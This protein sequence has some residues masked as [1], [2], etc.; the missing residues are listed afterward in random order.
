MSRRQVGRITVLG[1]IVTAVLATFGP[2]GVAGAGG[3]DPDP[4]DGDPVAGQAAPPSGT[5]AE[6]AVTV[7]DETEYRN[8][9]TAL[10]LDAAGP[11][12]ITLTA[13]ITLSVGTDPLY[14]GSQALTLDGAGFTID[15]AGT[16]QILNFD[17]NA[18][19]TVR[20]ITMRNGVTGG[21]GGAVEAEGDLVVEGSVFEDNEADSEGGAIDTPDDLVVED[22]V[23]E[24]NEAGSDGGAADSGGDATLLRSR[25]TRNVAGDDGGAVDTSND[26][27]LL[28]VDSTFEDNDADSEGAAVEAEEDVTLINSTLSGNRSSQTVNAEDGDINLLYVTLADNPTPAGDGVLDVD[29]GGTLTSFGTVIVTTGGQDA[30]EMNSGDDFSAVTSSYTYSTDDSCGLA[31]TGDTE[32]GADPGLGALA[33]NGGPTTTRLPATDSPLV[34]AIPTGD[35]DPTEP[36]DQRGVARPQD[37]NDDGTVG[38]DIGAVEVEEAAPPPPPPAPGPVPAAPAFTG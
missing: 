18:L 36:D 7:G 38:C 17:S 19:L 15:A 14:D 8:A 4:D 28:A 9:L 37:G 24:D 5:P 23:F 12:T 35:C 20:N 30:C 1:L 16:S 3:L 13:D 11:H 21:S 2:V 25:F 33:D 6:T 29:D 22:S 34:D 26:G 31:G 27:S 10:S 32:N